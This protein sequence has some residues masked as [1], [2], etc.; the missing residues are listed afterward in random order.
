MMHKLNSLGL[1][2]HTNSN[3]L[4]IQENIV[5]KVTDGTSTKESFSAN[6]C[7]NE[8]TPQRLDNIERISMI[9][10]S[11]PDPCMGITLSHDPS[12][13]FVLS[14]SSTYKFLKGNEYL[15]NFVL[16]IWCL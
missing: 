5:E 10:E 2:N 14:K 7:S 8:T 9:L 16:Q 15:D 6:Q 4:E 12:Q 13:L 11:I 1:L 3:E